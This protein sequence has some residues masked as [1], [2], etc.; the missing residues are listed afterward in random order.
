MEV[1]RAMVVAPASSS[2]LWKLEHVADFARLR[3]LAWSGNKLYAARGYT[4]VS[5]RIDNGPIEWHE[6]ASYDPP[7][8]RNLTGSTP[9][10]FRLVRDGFH[11][12]AFLPSGSLVAAVP[13]AI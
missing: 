3:A 13:G 4:L 11:A 5:A 1:E 7:W 6:V 2:T 8:W 12:L 9:L 10:T